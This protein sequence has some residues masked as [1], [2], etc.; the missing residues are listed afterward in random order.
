MGFLGKKASIALIRVSQEKC[1]RFTS[2]LQKGQLC[3]NCIGDYHKMHGFF[4]S[5]QKSSQ[6]FDSCINI[7]EI[8]QGR[9]VGI[10]PLIPQ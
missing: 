10:R 1:N 7:S 4:S 3:E 5:P 6:Q 9:V 8:E 2:K